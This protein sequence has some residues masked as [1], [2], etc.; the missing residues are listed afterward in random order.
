MN[1]QQIIDKIDEGHLF[2]PVFQREYVWKR[3]DVKAF[4]DSLILMS[5][6]RKNIIHRWGQSN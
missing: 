2:V 3:K 4:F 5:R 6:A 1:I